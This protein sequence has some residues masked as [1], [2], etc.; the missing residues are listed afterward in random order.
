MKTTLLSEIIALRHR[1]HQ[2]PETAFTET[3]TKQ[4]LMDFLRTHTSLQLTDHGYWFTAYYGCSNPMAETIAYRA[5]MD[6][7]PMEEGDTLP[8]HS[9]HP[10]KSCAC[11]HD[12]HSA[13]LAGFGW[14]LDK[15]KPD[16][17]VW[18][19][20]QHAEEVGG[21][22]EEC[23]AWLETVSPARVYAFH[24]MS[25]WPEG[26]V[27]C[28]PGLTHCASQGLTIRY[29]GKVAHASTPENGI[30]PTFALAELALA[31][32]EMAEAAGYT[33]PV[34]ATVV[35]MAVGSKNFGIAAW[36]GELSM[37]LRS[38]ADV[39]LTLLRERILDKATALATRERLEMSIT[40]ADIFPA[41]VNDPG[42][43]SRL[44]KAA[45]RAGLSF[46]TLPEPYRASED[47]GY[48]L[49]H[50][51]GVMCY[52]GNGEVWPPIHDGS[53]DFN[54]RIIPTVLRLF[55]Q[56]LE[57]KTPIPLVAIQA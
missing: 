53:Y 18:L 45:E 28:K 44:Q 15:A 31:V 30:N 1:L 48:Y 37:T 13:I 47:F 17:N 3:K 2:I 24:N 50:M 55:W 23:A 56:V 16:K 10:G 20:F 34:W 42:E 57:T 7:L 43:A 11:G 27:L 6:G 33:A 54:D 52:V 32:R 14:M 46:K 39:D 9:C 8:Y 36:E 40:E 5:D 4:T 26:M 12:G 51:P 41:T 25:G 22:G 38:R 35:H 19:V 29:R 21:G 49:R